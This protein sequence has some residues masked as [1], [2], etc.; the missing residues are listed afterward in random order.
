MVKYILDLP[1]HAIGLEHV[2][3]SEHRRWTAWRA[4][5]VYQETRQVLFK[6]TGRA[7][8]IEK[9]EITCGAKAGNSV[10]AGASSGGAD[11]AG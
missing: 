7:A 2:V 4:L 1:F 6:R 10:S 5:C 9:V 11:E 8:Q 3:S